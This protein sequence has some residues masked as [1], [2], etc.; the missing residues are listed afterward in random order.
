M[1]KLFFSIAAL[2]TALIY[3]T[4]RS[5]LGSQYFSNKNIKSGLPVCHIKTEDGTVVDLTDLCGTDAQKN[6]PD[7]PIKRLLKTKNCS[8]CNL[9]DVNLTGANLIGADLSYAN[10]S[11]AN[12]SGANLIGANLTGANTTNIILKR[13]VMPDGSIHD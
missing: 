10:L 8:K 6:S 9:K 11:G 13:T 7:S 2:S 1:L 12:L 4:D 5:S 3:L